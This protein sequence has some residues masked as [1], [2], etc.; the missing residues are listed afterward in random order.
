MLLHRDSYGLPRKK[1]ILCLSPVCGVPSTKKEGTDSDF[2]ETLPARGRK[3]QMLS[4]IYRAR[5]DDCSRARSRYKSK[6]AR[7]AHRPV[8]A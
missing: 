8:V 5:R 1:P 7:T 2:S 6:R 3:R 4:V